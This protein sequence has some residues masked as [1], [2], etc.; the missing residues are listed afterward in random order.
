MTYA[1]AR[2]CFAFLAG[3]LSPGFLSAEPLPNLT[4]NPDTI[5]VSGLSSG[6]YMAVQLQVAFSD[7]IAGAAVIAG[8]PF[9]CAQDRV[10]EAIS[11]CMSARSGGPDIATLVSNTQAM[12][13]TG[14]IADLGGL[15][16]DRVYMFS[17]TEDDT[18]TRPVMDALLR[19]YNELSVP[20]DVIRYET[21]VP[22][23]HAFL[24]PSGELPCSASETPFIN[25]CALDQA[26]DLLTWLY[27]PLAPAVPPREEGL[28]PFDQSE[29]I[30]NPDRISMGDTG[31]VYVPQLCEDGA[32]CDLHIA[33]HGCR[34]AESQIGDT[35]VRETGYLG[36]AEANNIV[37]LF[38]QAKT[39]LLLGNPKGC[40]DWWGY[41]DPDYATRNGPQPAAIARMATQLGAP[42]S[43]EAFCVDHEDFNFSHW[44]AGRA[45]PCGF[46][47]CAVG[48]GDPIGTSWGASTLY[49]SP[50][51]TFRTDSCQP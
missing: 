37:V 50:P 41:S 25:D 15:T 16:G 34:Q 13:E 45:E 38:P 29:V 30:P 22:A 36:W 33:L 44:Q 10:L 42:L 47:L 49:E 9:Y 12:A 32:P 11:T 8:G 40:W 31:F 35:Y 19:F 51:G 14:A 3:S 24:S 7:H 28:R 23:G 21:E 43:S 26:G 39:S 46:A 18:V 4:L 20:S 17:G 27:G 48:S 1:S 2:L 5:T 6:A